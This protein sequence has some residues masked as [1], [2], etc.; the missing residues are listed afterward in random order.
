MEFCKKFFQLYFNVCLKFLRS[1]S[2]IE[3]LYTLLF[4]PKSERQI[5]TIASESKKKK[6]SLWYKSNLVAPLLIIYAP[7][8]FTR[9]SED[10]GVLNFH[11]GL[12]DLT[13]TGSFTLLGINVMRTSLTLINEKIDYSLL[14]EEITKRFGE[15][16]EA[17][18]SRLRFY[19]TALTWIGGIFYV[20][21]VCSFIDASN[22]KVYYYL[23]L[24]LLFCLLS[25]VVARHITVVQTN[26]LDDKQ[27]VS[28]SIS[29]LSY[30]HKSD[31]KSLETIA[32]EEGLL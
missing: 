21:Q 22:T 16:V 30:N 23:P 12:I 24:I 19:I 7:Y 32:T 4:F 14:P 28:D 6:N 25:V 18:K 13:L 5:I 2:M 15:D 9:V 20:I 26:F 17:A 11:K 27:F 8:F 1:I 10:F 3:I 29:K 31:L